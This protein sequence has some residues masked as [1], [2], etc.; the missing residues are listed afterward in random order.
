MMPLHADAGWLA[1]LAER[2]S[3][4]EVQAFYEANPEYWR[5]THGHAPP[6]GEAAEGFDFRPP[7]EMPYRDWQI[8]LVRDRASRRIVGELSVA[9]DLLAPGVF[10]LGFFIIES[11]RQGSGLATEVYAAYEAWA[12]AAGRT[13]AA[14]RRRR[15]EYARRSILASTGIRRS[16]APGGLHARFAHAPADRDGEAGS[17]QYAGRFPAGGAARPAGLK[18]SSERQI[19]GLQPLECGFR[20]SLAFGDYT[21]PRGDTSRVILA[22]AI[23]I[24]AIGQLA[25]RQPRQHRGATARAGSPWRANHAGAA[26]R[27]SAG[28]CRAIPASPR[29]RSADTAP[30]RMSARTARASGSRSGRHPSSRRVER[31]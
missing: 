5:V 2:S 27:A 31:R 6:S 1:V 11:A 3:A 23:E 15:G 19:R 26:A 24:A 12:L 17:S 30:A 20:K 18:G 25:A 9:I 16:Q 29:A 13:L 8:W 7:A 28:V 4:D 21:L 22:E 14:A 10:H